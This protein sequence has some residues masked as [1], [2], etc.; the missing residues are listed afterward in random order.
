ME[1]FAIIEDFFSAI[2]LPQYRKYIF[3][4]LKAA[5]SKKY[6]KKEDPASLLYCQKKLSDLMGAA[7]LLNVKSTLVNGKKSKA[8]IAPAELDREIIDPSLYMDKNL[9]HIQWEVFPRN[10]SKK[11]FL[12]PYLA[13][14]HFFRNR[15]LKVWRRDL[16]EMI[17]Y[18]LS[19]H[20]SAEDLLDLKFLEINSQLQ[21][22]VEA[23]HLIW[24]REIN[25][26]Q[27][28]I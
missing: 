10:L 4:M 21:K 22:L 17:F 2:P 25:P 7:L 18:A 26:A 8:S 13:F 28:K 3:S 12:D 23:A 11:E 14:K 16:T 27:E 24:I 9:L 5:N 20:D 6:W 19:P 15:N 1:P